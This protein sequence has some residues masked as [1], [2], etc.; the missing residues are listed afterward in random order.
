MGFG[1]VLEYESGKQDWLAA[2]LPME[3]RAVGVPRAG[4]VARDEV[5][6]GRLDE[7]LGD[8]AERARAS[9]WNAAVVINEDRVVLGL[10]REEELGGDPDQR[11]EEAMRPGP[12][13]YRPHVHIVE[14]AQV[15]EEH[16]VPTI[17]ITTGEGVLVGVLRR[18]DAVAAAVEFQRRHQEEHHEHG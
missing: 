9:G 17:P 3:G 12:S 13:T 15:M 1:D 8:V 7:R 10:L 2:G 6:T 14:M 5:P 18:E 4:S 11:I 16:D